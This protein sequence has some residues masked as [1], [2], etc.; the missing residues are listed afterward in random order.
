MLR[1]PGGCCPHDPVLFSLVNLL[2]YGWRRYACTMVWITGIS[3]RAPVDIS[4]HDR[5]S[6]PGR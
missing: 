5:G 4:T 6:I 3:G 2:E 1:V